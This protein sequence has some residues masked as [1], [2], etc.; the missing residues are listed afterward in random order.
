MRP[1][2]SNDLCW[3][4]FLIHLAMQGRRRG[5]NCHQMKPNSNFCPKLNMWLCQDWGKSKTVYIVCLIFVAAFL[6]N[7]FDIRSSWTFQHFHKRNIKDVCKIASR[8]KLK[9]LRAEYICQNRACRFNCPG[10]E[11]WQRFEREKLFEMKVDKLCA[12]IALAFQ[13]G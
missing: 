6:S 13:F 3:V 5:Q 7:L 10:T 11:I 2:F 4:G 9:Y 8:R 12:C 1:D